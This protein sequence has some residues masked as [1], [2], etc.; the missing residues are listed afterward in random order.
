M[1]IAGS[2]RRHESVLINATHR[3]S[4]GVATSIT[5]TRYQTK[6]RAPFASLSLDRYD[7]LSIGWKVWPVNSA[8]LSRAS[9]TQSL[10]VVGFSS[11]APIK[12]GT[13]RDEPEAPLRKPRK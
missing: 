1:L 8:L 5:T 13:T 3:R 2:E 10:L 4:D 11:V 7:V 9:R 12:H 6:M